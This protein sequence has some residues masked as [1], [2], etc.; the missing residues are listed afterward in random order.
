MLFL[1]K[2]VIPK[3]LQSQ[4]KIQAGDRVRGGSISDCLHPV[5]V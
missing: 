2:D 5:S 1:G 3:L 4:A